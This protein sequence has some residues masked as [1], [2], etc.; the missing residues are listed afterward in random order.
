VGDITAL[1]EA[2]QDL[3]RLIAEYERIV[4][5]LEEIQ[6]HTSEVLVNGQEPIS[7][8]DSGQEQVF[9][10]ATEDFDGIKPLFLV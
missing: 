8:V 5:M 6:K 10:D 4:G 2:K 7:I 3:G 9:I 1:A